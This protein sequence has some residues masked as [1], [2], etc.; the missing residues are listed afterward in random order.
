VPQK[1]SASAR[2]A[3]SSYAEATTD[4]DPRAELMA[5]A[6]QAGGAS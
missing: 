3:L 5:R 1:L 6:R 4:H 2:D